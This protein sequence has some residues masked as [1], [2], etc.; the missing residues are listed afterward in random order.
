MEDKLYQ[1][2]ISSTYEDLKDERAAVEQVL[3]ACNCL[4]IGMERFPSADMEQFE[5]IKNAMKYTDYYVLIIGG[6]YGSINEE[7][8]ISYTEMEYNYAV[9]NK[10]PVLVFVKDET[11]ISKNQMDEHQSEL[12]L[13]IKK[14]TSNRLRG[15]T[16]KTTDELKVNVMQSINYEKLNNPRTGW[17]RADFG[18]PTE[19]LVKVNRLTDE[20]VELKK[21]IES[22]SCDKSILVGDFSLRL[23]CNFLY[24]DNSFITTSFTYKEYKFDYI[25]MYIKKYELFARIANVYFKNGN[26]I[27]D[28]INGIIEN[29]FKEKNTSR[30]DAFKAESEAV[31]DNLFIEK[32]VIKENKN[33]LSSFLNTSTINYNFHPNLNKK[34]YKGFNIQVSSESMDAIMNFLIFNNLIFKENNSFKFTDLGTKLFKS[35]VPGV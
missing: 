13:F 6:R 14:T 10:I 21:I 23:E 25:D 8:G 32:E 9:E 19:L 18:S 34:E 7:E 17:I 5:Y 4:P 28:D 2:F 27:I 26:F 1:V 3:I 30:Y 12:K 11:S 16:F 24:T 15:R 33:T 20:N 29:Y 31:F 35:I 22:N